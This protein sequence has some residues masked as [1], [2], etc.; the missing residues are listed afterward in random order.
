MKQIVSVLKWVVILAIVAGL[1]TLIFVTVKIG[2]PLTTDGAVKKFTVEPGMTTKQIARNLESEKLISKY[3][4]FDLYVYFKKSGTKIQAG[5]Y[6]LSST[7]PIRKI[8][9]ILAAG[10][11]IPTDVKFTVIEGWSAKDIA[12]NLEAAGI[13]QSKDF[14]SAVAKAG[15]AYNADFSFLSMKPRTAGLEGFLFPDTYYFSSTAKPGDVIRKMLANFEKKAPAGLDYNTLILASIVEREVGRNVFSGAKLS[16]A[17]AEKLQEERRLVAGVFI[18]RMARGMALE[19][20]ATVGYV[21]GSN[22][23]MATLDELKIDSPYNTYKYRGL[24]PTPISN[25]SL[26]SIM[27]AQHPAKTD[28]LFFL[29]APDGTAH[30]AKTLAEHAANRAMYLK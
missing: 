4:Y 25:P 30:F 16:K 1:A 23:R 15:Q 5:S 21:T 19:S 27:A 7:M 18:N 11:A 17:D 26:D 14:S 8:E 28:Y 10:K 3:L 22:S 24:P 9:Q 6:N 29:S 12:K 13:A 20:D 2:Q